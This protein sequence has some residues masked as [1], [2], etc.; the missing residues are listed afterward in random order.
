M[1]QIKA[2]EEQAWQ[3][4]NT[5]ILPIKL[6]SSWCTYVWRAAFYL[7]PKGF[8]IAWYQLELTVNHHF[9]EYASHN[10]MPLDADIF[11]ITHLFN[12]NPTVS[13]DNIQHE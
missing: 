9:H 13:L 7:I 11:S 1:D 4:S 2:L 6:L 10:H 5:I 8:P 12:A 3:C